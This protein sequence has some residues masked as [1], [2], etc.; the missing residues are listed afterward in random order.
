MAAPGSERATHRW[1]AGTTAL[2]ELLDFD[3]E[4]MN[5]MQL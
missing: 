2:G 1:L 4:R 3:F 5:P